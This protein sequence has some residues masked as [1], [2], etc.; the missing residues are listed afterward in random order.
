[1][2]NLPQTFKTEVNSSDCRRYQYFSSMTIV[3]LFRTAVMVAIVD[4]VAVVT[5]SNSDKLIGLRNIFKS[6][7]SGPSFSYR[8]VVIPL[9]Y[10]TSLLIQLTLTISFLVLG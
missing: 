7:K 2:R 1:M 9:M 10:G 8:Q 6:L 5:V 3:E 4:V